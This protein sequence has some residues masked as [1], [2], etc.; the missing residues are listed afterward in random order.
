MKSIGSP[1]Q[2]VRSPACGVINPCL[3]REM[4]LRAYA[5]GTPY[6]VRAYYCIGHYASPSASIPLPHSFRRA[7]FHA[8][9]LDL[10]P[11][12]TTGVWY[13]WTRLANPRRLSGDS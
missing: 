13:S 10:L 9:C 1:L 8:Y 2:V 3:P 11:S 12:S 6:K 7:L 5:T 4:T